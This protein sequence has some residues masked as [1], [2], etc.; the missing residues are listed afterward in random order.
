VIDV[1]ES[2]G[3]IVAHVATIPVRLSSGGPVQARAAVGGLWADLMVHPEARGLDLFMRLS[4]SHARRAKATGIRQLY[5]FPNDNSYPILKRMLGW[6]TVQEI[7]ALEAPLERLRLPRSPL[8]AGWFFEEINEYTLGFDDFWS[9]VRP[10][11]ISIVRDTAWLRWRYL[12]KPK[13]NYG[14]W[15]LWNEQGRLAG[16]IAAKVFGRIG[17]VMDLWA[18]PGPASAALM[19]HAAEW[20]RSLKVRRVSAWAIPSS[21]RRKPESRTRRVLGPG[22]RRGDGMYEHYLAWGLKP[23]GPRTHFAAIPFGG[24]RWEVTK[25]DSDVF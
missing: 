8:P 17:D 9:C 21:F 24:E 11:A 1:A 23:V 14:R 12:R 19:A 3:R 13:Y 7:E 2:S 10:A 18:E 4:E 22:L 25:G 20:F 6:K 16:W 5:A 15:A